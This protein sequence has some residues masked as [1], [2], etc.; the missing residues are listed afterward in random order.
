MCTGCGFPAAPGHW[1]EAGSPTAGDR[2]RDRARRAAALDR[3]LRPFGLTVH[4]T[5][6]VPGYR[7]ATLSGAVTLVGTLEDLWVEAERIAGRAVDPLD[8]V[9][10]DG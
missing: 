2:L 6:P 10:L 8:P 7:L 3:L 5:H 9:F 4:D 1:T